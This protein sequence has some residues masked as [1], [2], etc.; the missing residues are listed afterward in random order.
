MVHDLLVTQRL[1]QD[2]EAVDRESTEEVDS[3]QDQEGQEEPRHVTHDAADLVRVPKHKFSTECRDV[4][5]CHGRHTHQAVDNGNVEKKHI[6]CLFEQMVLDQ[7]RDDD[8]QV[9][10][11]AHHKEEEDQ[12]A[13]DC[14]TY[15]VALGDLPE[16]IVG[17][18]SRAHHAA[19]A[20][21]KAAVVHTRS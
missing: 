19:V 1:G 14:G 3:G 6:A 10:H 5:E 13:C 2:D 17:Y 21:R 7:V 20:T 11:K 4:G 16:G 8:E 9:P 15:V 18:G 12:A